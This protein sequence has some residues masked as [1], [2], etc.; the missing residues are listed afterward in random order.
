[1]NRSHTLLAAR[2]C[3]QHHHHQQQQQRCRTKPAQAR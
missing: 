2:A 1:M 3:A